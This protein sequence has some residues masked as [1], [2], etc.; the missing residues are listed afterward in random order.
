MRRSAAAGRDSHDLSAGMRYGDYS[1]LAVFQS[2]AR[3][4]QKRLRMWLSDWWLN[5][6][7]LRGEREP[8]GGG[9]PLKVRRR[10]LDFNPYPAAAD[11]DGRESKEI[12][13]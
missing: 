9:D 1:R 12:L 4:E 8:F 6:C 11:K 10:D 2:Y 5:R 13:I 3:S 7:G